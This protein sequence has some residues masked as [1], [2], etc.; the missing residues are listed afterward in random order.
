MISQMVTHKQSLLSICLKRGIISS[1]SVMYAKHTALENRNEQ[2]NIQHLWNG[3][4][5]GD[6][7]GSQNFQ[8]ACYN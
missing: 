1:F 7:Q 2:I 5:D 6:H 3:G 8:C 4:L